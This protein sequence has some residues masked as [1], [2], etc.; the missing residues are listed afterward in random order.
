MRRV[1]ELLGVA[2]GVQKR[3]DLASRRVAPTSQAV[4]AK[5]FRGELTVDG[6]QT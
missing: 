3:I 6:T 2:N 5:A 4:L 1:E